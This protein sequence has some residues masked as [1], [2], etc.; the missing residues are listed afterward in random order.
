MKLNQSLTDFYLTN[1]LTVY[2]ANIVHKKK[3]HGLKAQALKT[4]F[5]AAVQM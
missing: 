1:H 5:L 3:A 2:R 4:S